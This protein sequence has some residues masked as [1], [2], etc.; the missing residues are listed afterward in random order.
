MH[1]EDVLI[2]G[3][4]RMKTYNSS[5][6]IVPRGFQRRKGKYRRPEYFVNHLGLSRD[7]K[8]SFIMRWHESK[9]GLRMG[10]K[11]VMINKQLSAYHYNA[12]QSKF[13]IIQGF[14]VTG[15]VWYFTSRWSKLKPQRKR[16]FLV[17]EKEP[18]SF[19]LKDIDE[20][21]QNNPG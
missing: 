18:Q 21:H 13:P 9:A 16:I 11:D 12:S 1:L 10:P 5:N 6:N 17:P 3:I 20:N 8:K 7:L 15:T 14:N 19:R 4:L 2:T